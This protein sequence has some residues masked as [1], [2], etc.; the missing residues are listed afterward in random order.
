[1]KKSQSLSK[2]SLAPINK[3]S[4]KIDIIKVKSKLQ[5]INFA[6][7][8]NNRATSANLLKT[9]GKVYRGSLNKPAIILSKD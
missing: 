3:N 4:Q 6:T 1:M 7:T 2:Y 9:K 5:T 8:K